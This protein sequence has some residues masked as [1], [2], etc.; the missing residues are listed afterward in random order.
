MPHFLV[1]PQPCIAARHKSDWQI[2][3]AKQLAPIGFGL[4][5][6]GQE[7][8][9]HLRRNSFAPEKFEAPE[10]DREFRRQM[11]VFPG[12]THAK[13]LRALPFLREIPRLDSGVLSA[14]ILLRARQ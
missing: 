2:R 13:P 7:G 12:S 5:Q 14:T 8:V 11:A 4:G 10:R 6:Q 1:G 3:R 9:S